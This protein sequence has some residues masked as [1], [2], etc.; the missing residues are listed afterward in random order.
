MKTEKKK[1]LRGS[2]LFTVVCVMALLIIFLTGTL[3]LASAAGNRAHRSYSVSQANYT[4]RAAIASFTDAHIP[5][6]MDNANVLTA[7]MRLLILFHDV[8]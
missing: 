4:A 1:T 3:A 7:R 5:G 8:N 2:I 6:L